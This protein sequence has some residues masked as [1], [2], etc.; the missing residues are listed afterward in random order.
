MN[1]DVK[2]LLWVAVA[3]VV[4][5]GGGWLAYNASQPQ[6]LPKADPKLLTN[7]QSH[8]S[9]Q[10]TRTYPVTLVEFGDYQCPA[11]GFAE[12][13][14][15]KI[16]ADNPNV[17]LVFRNFPLAMHQHA[18]LAAE[19]AEAAGAQGKFW[20]MHNAISLN[21]DIWSQ[22]AN[23]LDAFVEIAKQLK[24][25][26]TK[27]KQDVTN[28]KF[29]AIINKDVQDGTAAGVH[30]TPTFFINGRQYLGDLNYASLQAAVSEVL[31]EDSTQ[32]KTN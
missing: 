31:K 7:D 3:V 2:K 6:N 21:Q 4:V 12:P 14:V 28:N 23:P 20:A 30:A 22:M 24:L 8:T 25:D 26:V 11:C 15:E 19:A 5:I 9:A 27:F 18:I 16:L 32:Q 17:K 1:K 29:A 10:G 13:I